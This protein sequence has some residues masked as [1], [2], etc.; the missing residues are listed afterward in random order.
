[1]SKLDRCFVKSWSAAPADGSD[2]C[3]YTCVL[4]LG[5]DVE[6][7]DRSLTIPCAL[8]IEVAILDPAFPSED[9]ESFTLRGRDL[10]PFT[11]DEVFSGPAFGNGLPGLS[12][13]SAQAELNRNGHLV[14]SNLS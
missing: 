2:P 1:M 13:G 6:L 11:I 12:L 10:K 5:T 8:R 14:V 7:A 4:C 3:R 9:L